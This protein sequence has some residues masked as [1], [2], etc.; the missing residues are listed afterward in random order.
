MTRLLVDT[1][2]LLWWMAND[3]AR[4][5]ETARRQLVDPANRIIVSAVSVWETTI[6]RALGKLD[7]PA[8]LL[9]RLE[10]SAVEL[11]PITARHADHVG[12]LPKHHGDPFDRLLVAQAGLE[13]L[14]LVS[15]DSEVRRYDI[16]VV[17]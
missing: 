3:R 15:G 4:L 6:K 11:L 5:S 8:D 13:R 14:A 16:T 2:V 9:E 10:Q 7:A 12:R 17:W 1:H